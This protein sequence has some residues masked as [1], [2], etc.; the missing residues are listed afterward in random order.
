M[1]GETVRLFVKGQVLGYKRSKAN[2]VNH[3]ALIKVDGV[4]SK[5]ETAFYLG[6]RIA[7]IYRAQTE[8]KGSTYRVVWGKACRSHGN[9]GVLRCKFRKNLPPKSLGATVR[10]MMFP[11]RI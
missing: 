3:T 11:S 7:Y 10:I 5:E 1:G 9:A 6:K 8:K 2:Q 4:E